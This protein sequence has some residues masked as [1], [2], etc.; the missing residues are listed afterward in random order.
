MTRAE[1]HQRIDAELDT[2]ASVYPDLPSH[3]V[4]RRVAEIAQ[5]YME[6]TVD[7]RDGGRGTVPQACIRCAKVSYLNGSGYCLRCE[8]AR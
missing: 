4:L 2:W 7:Q 5:R 6:W 3:Q 1:L 8:R